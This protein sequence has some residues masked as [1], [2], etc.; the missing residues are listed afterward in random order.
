[1]IKNFLRKKV[2][3]DIT[4]LGHP[5]C[6]FLYAHV[7]FRFLYGSKDLIFYKEKAKKRH[8]DWIKNNKILKIKRNFR[9][10]LYV[11]VSDCIKK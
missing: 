4:L 6:L 10:S 5:S 11:Q 8:L 1:M 3:P 9:G 7:L 2:S